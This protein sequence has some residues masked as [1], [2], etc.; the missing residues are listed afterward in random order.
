MQYKPQLSLQQKLQPS[1]F[2]NKSPTTNFPFTSIPKRESISHTK[3]YSAMQ[4]TVSDDKLVAI[5]Q[6]FPTSDTAVSTPA[7]QYRASEDFQLQRLPNE[8]LNESVVRNNEKARPRPQSLTVPVVDSQQSDHLPPSALKS[9]LLLSPRKTPG[10][11][12]TIRLDTNTF[13]DAPSESNES[14]SQNNFSTPTRAVVHSM[15][16]IQSNEF[17]ETPLSALTNTPQTPPPTAN[18]N[19]D[20]TLTSISLGSTFSIFSD[21]SKQ[22]K[23][24]ALALMTGPVSPNT[25]RAILQADMSPASVK[26][27]LQEQYSQNAK[28]DGM[29]F[30][31]IMRDKIVQ[32]LQ[33]SCDQEYAEKMCN[34]HNLT[35]VAVQDLAAH[36]KALL[37][38]I[39]C[40]PSIH[41]SSLMK[42]FHST[43]QGVSVTRWVSSQNIVGTATILRP[44][45]EQGP[46]SAT[47]LPLPQLAP[48]KSL[49]GS[50]FGS[51]SSATAENGPHSGPTPRKS[52]NEDCNSLVIS[53]SF[54][55]QNE[56]VLYYFT[57]LTNGGQQGTIYLTARYLCM[58]SSL[59]GFINTK[60]EIFL[61]SDLTEYSVTT[62][63][64]ALN[65][66]SG[67]NVDNHMAKHESVDVNNGTS[68]SG[69]AA[70]L[71]SHL[72]LLKLV[73]QSGQRE[74]LLRP[75]LVDAAR[76]QMVFAEILANFRPS[77]TEDR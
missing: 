25:A 19:D 44:V 6:P 1:S 50:F 69:V 74:L 62:S 41:K 76:V 45:N 23:T 21:D 2:K 26:V 72:K 27:R 67:E 71:F 10:R 42:T 51:S 15:A 5:Q 73:F 54:P 63:G 38:A 56:V 57:M 28:V 55:I 34:R 13:H 35:L 49:F 31:L 46:A 43:F 30:C 77:E 75:L 48:T 53:S 16:A 12:V 60:K 17:P 3:T 65:H 64:E 32:E 4:A 8:S 14:S 29:V 61:L 37:M 68:I 36:K 9:S 11:S 52:D 33:N 18:S 7:S 22:R 66:N 40:H 58:V 59:M 70:G 24:K 47:K 20:D 39:I